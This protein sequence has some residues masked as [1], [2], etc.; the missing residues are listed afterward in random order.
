[1]N[2][3]NKMNWLFLIRVVVVS[4]LLINQPIWAQTKAKTYTPPLEFAA[5]LQYFQQWQKDRGAKQL[6]P[7]LLEQE[8]FGTSY[9]V[10]LGSKALGLQ[11]KEVVLQNPF[12]ASALPLSYSVIYQKHLITLFEPGYFA[13][14]D[15]KTL[16]RNQTLEQRLNRQKFQYHWLLDK[17][18]V[19]LS[20]GRF[21]ILTAA[22]IWTPYTVPIPFLV[23]Q[24][25]LFEDERYLS[26]STCN[27]E[28]GG[29]V[30]FYDKQSHQYY[31]TEATCPNSITKHDGKYWVLASLGHGLSHAGVQ[32]I[33]DP[34]KLI[35]RQPTPKSA[36]AGLALPG[37]QEKDTPPQ[38]KSQ[39][40]FFYHGIQMFGSFV[41][42]GQLLYMVN[43]ADRTFLATIENNRVTVVDPL[44]NSRIYTH[45][46]ITTNYGSDL[47]L[48]NIDFYGQGREKEVSCLLLTGNQIIRIDWGR[49]FD[50]RND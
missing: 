5:L 26:F 49:K 3:I 22:G 45:H 46:P 36:G 30:Y 24:P 7:P 4:A 48:M 16:T 11:K 23:K 14:Y 21:F 25:K 18:L 40:A 42:Q 32:I 28:F 35:R 9:Q 10:R 39:T 31:L 37:Y 29:N 13:C 47:N 20:A 2:L 15:L 1:M 41:R 44:F 43:L 38:A 17:Q 50:V 8:S 34:T 12:G 33:A 6:A 27:G 19:G